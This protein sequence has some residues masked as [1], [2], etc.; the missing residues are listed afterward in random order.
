[1]VL[2]IRDTPNFST[3]GNL[4][5]RGGD[6]DLRL[7]IT[8][9]QDRSEPVGG[10]PR[11][12]E[13]K[14]VLQA[15]DNSERISSGTWIQIYGENLAPSDC[16]YV[17]NVSLGCDW[18]NSFEGIRAPTSLK[19]VQVLIGGKRAAISFL[20]QNQINAQVPDDLPDGRVA[21]QVIVNGVASN[22]VSA[23]KSKVSPALLNWSADGVKSYVRAILPPLPSDP[24]NLV[25]YA[26]PE[27][28]IQGFQFRP[29]RPG[30]IL[31]IFAVGCGAT[32]PASAAGQIVQQIQTPIG[33]PLLASPVQF[34]FGE[35]PG[36]QAVVQGFLAVGNIGLCQLNVT[37]PNLSPGEH[38][39]EARID[40]APTGQT[41][42]TLIGP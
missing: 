33:A 3:L 37:V 18:Q 5:I 38:R 26:G 24:P 41:L 28:Y 6:S 21:V 36:T 32:T 11:L 9:D 2:T 39:V 42:Y 13:T 40:G 25:T 14:P 12:R 16:A 17:A 10:G 4:Q 31:T 23:I 30:D 20:N 29:A 19:N 22:E 34:T 35:G 27:N 15:F 1:V 8:L 7:N